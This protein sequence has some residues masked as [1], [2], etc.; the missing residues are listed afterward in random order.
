VYIEFPYEHAA[1]GSARVFGLNDVDGREITLRC[2]GQSRTILMFIKGDSAL[3]LN[4][5][6]A[7]SLPYALDRHQ[8]AVH[9]GRIIQLIRLRSFSKR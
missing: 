8:S 1:G 2:H 4:R 6:L 5:L 3:I 7:E 9:L